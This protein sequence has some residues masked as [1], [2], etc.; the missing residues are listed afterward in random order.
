VA[1]SVRT[2]VVAERRALEELM[3]RASVASARYAEDLRAHPEA[4]SVPADQFEDGLVRVAERAGAV[5]GFA[6]LLRPA[7]GACELDAIFVEPELMGAGVG[8]ALI[9]DA[10]ARAQGWGATEIQVVANPD[11]MDFY[12]RLGFAGGGHVAT[13][14][15]PGLRMRRPVEP[16]GG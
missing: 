7:E 12:E 11:A 10:V 15:G 14:F 5:A 8:R 2:A 6:V 1:V 3:M 4:V 13:R 9:E 16:P